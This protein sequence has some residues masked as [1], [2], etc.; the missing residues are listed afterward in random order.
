M[1]GALRWDP[2]VGGGPWV[3]RDASPTPL[4]CSLDL[5]V[6]YGYSLSFLTP[7]RGHTVPPK[8]NFGAL[9]REPPPSWGTPQKTLPGP[10]IVQKN[11]A[12]SL[13]P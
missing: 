9:R 2:P 13:G 12:L 1:F 4:L 3:G 8:K 6:H 11:P 10:K 5:G 7:P